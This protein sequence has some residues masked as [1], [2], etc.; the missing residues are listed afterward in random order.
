MEFENNP[1]QRKRS[2]TRMAVTK[3]QMMNMD[4][5]DIFDWDVEMLDAGL[6]ELNITIG[7]TWSKPKKANELNK[8]VEQMN[9]GSKTKTPVQTQDPNYFMMKTFQAMQEQMQQAN[10]EFMVKMF[11]KFNETSDAGRGNAACG[12]KTSHA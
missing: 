6:K 9:S 8:A 3:Q 1:R 2:T 10:Q 11:E 7:S 4:P 12:N 5:E